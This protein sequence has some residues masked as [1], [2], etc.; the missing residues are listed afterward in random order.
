M[1]NFRKRGLIQQKSQIEKFR[2]Y[3]MK[4]MK[5]AWKH[6]IKCKRKGKKDL[7]A[8]REE[9]LAKNL[10][11]NDK[12]LWASLVQFGER[13]KVWKPFWKESLKGQTL[14]FLKTRFTSFDWLKISFDW[15]KP[16]LLIS[17]R[18]SR[19]V[20]KIS[21]Q[22]ANRNG[23]PLCSTSDKIPA[24]SNVFRAFRFISVK[25]SQ[26]ARFGRYMFNSKRWDSVKKNKK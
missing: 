2:K 8:Y 14:I 1:I 7:P 18:S 16:L 11:E 4:C 6:E 3:P 21:Y 26:N 15:S 5:N 19:N 12:K 22:Y 25:S 24:Y 13:E 23:T 9:N 17:F 10:E 20:R